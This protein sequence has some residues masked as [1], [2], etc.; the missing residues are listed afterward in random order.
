MAS[1]NPTALGMSHNNDMLN[2]QRR[3]C[4]FNCGGGAVT[5]QIAIRWGDQI[6][7]IS[8]GGL[9]KDRLKD[10]PALMKQLRDQQREKME[11]MLLPLT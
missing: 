9:N 6:G 3:H 8:K 11:G 10:I 4:I 1:L 2:L 5:G 7:D